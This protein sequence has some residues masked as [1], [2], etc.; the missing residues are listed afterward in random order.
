VSGALLPEVGISARPHRVLS[1]STSDSTDERMVDHLR[2]HPD[3]TKHS[4]GY[5]TTEISA[6]CDRGESAYEDPLTITQDGFV[7]EG[8]ALWQLA[9]LQKRRT[10]RCI[11]RE[12]SREQALLHIIDRNRGSKGINDFRP[13]PAGARAGTVV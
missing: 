12:M 9:R 7:V 8:Y 11:V 5:S 4:S 3:F 10:V 2:A 1:T 6:L 13:H